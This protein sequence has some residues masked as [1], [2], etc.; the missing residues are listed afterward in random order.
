VLIAFFAVFLFGSVPQ[1]YRKYAVI[2]GG[3]SATEGVQLEAVPV[4]VL[5]FMTFDLISLTSSRV[6]NVSAVDHLFVPLAIPFLL[7]FS[8]VFYSVDHAITYFIFHIFLLL[9]LS[10]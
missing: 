2:N 10:F 4:S 5:F 3:K 6:E 7:G 9:F 8:F 1:K